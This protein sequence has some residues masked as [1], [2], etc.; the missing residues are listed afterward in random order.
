MQKAP[1]RGRGLSK[2]NPLML[3][4]HLTPTRSSLA[5]VLFT[6]ATL[7]IS[8][9][10]GCQANTIPTQTMTGGSAGQAAGGSSAAGGS[11]A[12]SAGAHLGAGGSAG[13]GGAHAGSSGSAGTSGA[14]GTS[15][16]TGGGGTGG[17]AGMSMGTGGSA[18]MSMGTGGSAGSGGSMGCSSSCSPGMGCQAGQCVTIGTPRPL[19]PLSTS[20]A[21]SHSPTLHWA[22]PS[23][24]DGAQVQLCSDR[25]LTSNCQTF[26][27]MGSSGKPPMSLSAGVYF[28][29][30]AGALGGNVGTS[31]SPVWELLVGS[32]NPP[33]DTSWGS[34]QDLNGDGLADVVL[35]SLPTGAS[36]TKV[37]VYL[38]TLQQG[39]N[40]STLGTILSNN[41]T[42]AL[43]TIE[44]AGDVNG[45]GYAD[46]LVLSS[47]STSSYVIDLY[48]GGGPKGL[49]SSTPTQMLTPTM[50]NPISQVSSA[51]DVN[52]DGYADVIVG[53][54][55]M[56][57][58]FLYLGSASGLSAT[59]IPV[60]APSMGMT[61]FGQSVAGAGDVNGDG[62]GDL[63]VGATD[64]VY[65]YL[66]SSS[67][68]QAASS[69][70]QI[71]YGNL[72]TNSSFG[73]SVAGGD[74]DGDGYS[75]L[76]V[77]ANALSVTSGSVTSNLGGVITYPGGKGLST[78][79]TQGPV[80]FSGMADFGQLL[81]RGSDVNG[82][83]MADFL[84]G[85]PQNATAYL[86]LGNSGFFS[87]TSQTPTP[88]SDMAGMPSSSFGS[89][90]LL[91]GDYD[92][93]GITDALVTTGDSSAG[94]STNTF[95]SKLFLT[96][97]SPFVAISSL[98]GVF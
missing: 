25:A 57:T 54:A 44:N 9:A 10:A 67:W 78:S 71:M 22:L 69:P 81:S 63:L 31:F 55:T 93:D 39:P 21:T 80:I 89:N 53:V 79:P 32:A 83:G 43:G 16:G 90:V 77:G 65:L 95:P 13:L 29:R 94:S 50:S 87:Q 5:L 48:L 17:S 24:A 68:S 2:G 41:T 76:I 23:H 97:S 85:A 1:L 86:V 19:A 60:A 82:D 46:L 35:S 7:W 74:L 34:N 51:G 45:D 15:M 58:A 75:D 70:I 88:L 61:N 12:G 38:G 98:P 96:G 64:Q 91:P 33:V 14:A 40:Q 6:G 56:S 18:G 8:F 36:T 28:W 20:T 72:T 47:S 26:T 30:V 27:A 4:P 42:A 11:T 84:V 92:G 52:G 3:R 62:F 59:P 37:T 66:G 73:V 49:T